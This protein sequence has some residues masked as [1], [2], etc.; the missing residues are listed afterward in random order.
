[1][2]IYVRMVVLR[3]ACVGGWM[4]EMS[5]NVRNIACDGD[6]GIGKVSRCSV[7]VLISRNEEPKSVWYR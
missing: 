1:M 4:A 6:Y 5:T 7:G 3:F 2:R